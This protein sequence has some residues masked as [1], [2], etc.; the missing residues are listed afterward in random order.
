MSIDRM[1]RG[2]FEQLARA[3]GYAVTKRDNGIYDSSHTSLMRTTWNAA[4]A[5][6]AANV[7]GQPE[8]R[9]AEN[10]TGAQG[11]GAGR[12]EQPVEFTAYVAALSCQTKTTEDLEPG[13][14]IACRA[15]IALSTQRESPQPVDCREAFE[16][17]IVQFEESEL[18]KPSMIWRAWQTVWKPKR[19]VSAQPKEDKFI[20][21]EMWMA[22]VDGKTGT[23]HTNYA[24]GQSDENAMRNILALLINKGWK[25]P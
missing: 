13:C 12:T 11:I 21:S 20:I 15:K 8:E 2:A 6:E 14:C 19:E 17:W 1:E 4:I 16:K 9:G 25:Q 10:G 7:S 18:L 3:M 5:Y 23:S 24:A 22:Y